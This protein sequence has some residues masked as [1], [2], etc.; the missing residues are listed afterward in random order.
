MQLVQVQ[1]GVNQEALQE[2]IAYREEDLKKPLTPRGIKMTEK[3]LLQWSEPEQM[4]MVEEAITNTWRGLHYVE[5]PRQAS[6]RQTNIIDDL[7][8]KSWAV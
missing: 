6:S 7:T 4:R 3:K 5:P 8:D 1:I 2:W